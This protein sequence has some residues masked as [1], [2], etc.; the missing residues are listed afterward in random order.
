MGLGAHAWRSG[1]G[2]VRLT[3][4]FW[5]PQLQAFLSCTDARPESQRFDPIA[6]Y[7]AAG[8]P[9]GCA[10]AGDRPVRAVARAQVSAAGCLS[11]AERTQAAVQPLS[12]AE[13]AAGV[14]PFTSWSALRECHTRR[15]GAGK[16]ESVVS[17]SIGRYAMSSA[18]WAR[19]LRRVRTGPAPA[20]I[21]LSWTD[22]V[23]RH[24]H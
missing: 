21:A 9:A 20:A 7:R 14:T 23:S 10:C 5:S 2:Y 3:M 12:A 6:R 4:M 22:L 11:A 1:S 13:L 15:P 16:G 24:R 18:G 17:T 8:H 19:Q